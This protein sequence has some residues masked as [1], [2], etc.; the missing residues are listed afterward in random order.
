MYWEV[1]M[2]IYKHEV[3]YYETDRMGITH[4]SNYVRWMEEARTF[5][6]REIGWP[7]ERIEEE[8]IISPVTSLSCEYKATSTFADE[9]SIEITVKGVKSARLSFEYRMLNQDGT[10]VCTAVSEHS[11]MSK[12]GKFVNLKRD[13]SIFFDLLKEQS[14]LK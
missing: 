5:F 1:L 12:E 2:F 14:E 8:G 11:F 13:Y 10:I 9:I 4:H 3:Q 7:Y 6:L